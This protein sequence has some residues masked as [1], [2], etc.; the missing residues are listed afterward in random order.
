MEGI[1]QAEIKSF[2]E[3]DEVRP[4]KAHG[5]AQIVN[6]GAGTVGKGVF[7]PGWRWSEDVKP[8]AGTDSC[9]AAHFGYVESG[10]MMVRMD[11]G[12]EFEVSAGNIAVIPPGHDAWVDDEECIFIDFAGMGDYAK[13]N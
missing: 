4:F 11:S 5:E 7:Q 13:A 12:E 8:L 1:K 3:P 10:R 2:D 6:V 9:E